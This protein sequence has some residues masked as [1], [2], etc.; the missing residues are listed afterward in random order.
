MKIELNE[1]KKD[2]E[3]YFEL[4]MKETIEIT[5]DGKPYAELAATE[6]AKRLETVRELAGSI[7]SDGDP[8]KVLEERVSDYLAA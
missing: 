5:K 8:M 7:H 3:K 2:V 4:A 6:K 1:F